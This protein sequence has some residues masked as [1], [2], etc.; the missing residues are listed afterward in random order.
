V[1][2]EPALHRRR[3]LGLAAIAG[4]GRVAAHEWAV[5]PSLTYWQSE[6]VFL[7]ALWEHA[8]D[9]LAVTHDRL[10]IQA[11]FAMGPHKHELF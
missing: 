3:A 2:T 10:T 9:A 4:A 7:R 5:T 8:R 1:E 6:F 11:V